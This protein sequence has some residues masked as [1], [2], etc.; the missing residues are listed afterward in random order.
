MELAASSRA[1]EEG[2]SCFPGTA[3]VRGALDRLSRGRTTVVIAH[4]LSTVRQAD[5]I[6]VLDEGRLVEVGT[7]EALTGRAGLYARLVARQGIG[8]PVGD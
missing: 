6:M 8:K 4:R 3:R 5:Q 7:H 1:S 2:P